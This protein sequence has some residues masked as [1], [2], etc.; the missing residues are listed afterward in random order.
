MTAAR[1]SSHRLEGCFG[2]GSW[3]VASEPEYGTADVWRSVLAA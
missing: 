3:K 2:E 1:E